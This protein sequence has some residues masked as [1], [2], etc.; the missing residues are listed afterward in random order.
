MQTDYFDNSPSTSGFSLS[1]SGSSNNPLSLNDYDE[2]DGSTGAGDNL[3]KVTDYVGTG[4]SNA[5]LED[6][7]KTGRENAEARYGQTVEDTSDQ[8]QEIVKR[9]QEMMAGEDEVSDTIRQSRN[10]QIQMA[11]AQAGPAG[12]TSSQERQLSR[13]AESDISSALVAK[14]NQN[15]TEYQQLIGN[16]LGG[17]FST[18]MGIGGLGIAAEDIGNDGSGDG[19]GIL[20]WLFG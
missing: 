8:I 3:D 5:T 17:Q 15:L 19:G 13:S 2:D 12:I 18:E 4:S 20:D 14:Q 16:I 6:A 7:L 11:R 9:R 10:R 1:S